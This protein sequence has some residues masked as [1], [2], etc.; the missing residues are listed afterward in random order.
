MSRPGTPAARAR[1]VFLPALLGAVAVMTGLV[2]LEAGGY[3]IVR[4][5]VSI[6]A[7]IVA[8]LAAQH[9]SWPWI[10]PLAVVAIIW[11]PV[12]PFA[13]SGVAW[14]AGHIVGAAVFLAAALLVRERQAG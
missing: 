12:L 3:A 13:F 6:L 11:N 1:P 14:A 10:I 2:F 7:L 9:G 8:V 4:Y 5:A